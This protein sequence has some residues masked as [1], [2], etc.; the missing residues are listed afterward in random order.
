MLGLPS[1][2][3]LKALRHPLLRNPLRSPLRH[4][5]RS[6]LRHPLRSPLRHPL[7]SRLRH[8]LRHPL[9]RNPLR[10]PLLDPLLDPLRNPLHARPAHTEQA[11]FSG[12]PSHATIARRFSSQPN[13]LTFTEKRTKDRGEFIDIHDIGGVEPEDYDVLIT[14]IDNNTLRSEV[15]EL[16]GIPYLKKATKEEANNVVEIGH[17]ITYGRKFRIIFPCVVSFEDKAHWVFFIVDTGAPLT[18]LSAQAGK[19]LSIGSDPAPVK[20]AGYIHPVYLSPE[21]SHFANV[22]ILGNDFCTAYNVALG[23]RR[24]NRTVELLFGWGTKWEP[25]PKL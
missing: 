15:A 24:N 16:I 19:L 13:P 17:G 9:L 8:P 25:K 12:P 11:P 5:L 1:Q 20:I 14:D 10:S 23:P 4:P 7:R 6:P 18:Y 21:H 2:Q 22:N 3:V